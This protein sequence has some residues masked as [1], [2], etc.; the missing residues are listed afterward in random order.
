M[1]NS[2]RSQLWLPEYEVVDVG[3]HAQLTLSFSVIGGRV[4]RAGLMS[5]GMGI[6]I[7]WA[8]VLFALPRHEQH[9]LLVA[10]CNLTTQEDPEFETSLGY[11]L[12]PCLKEEGRERRRRRERKSEGG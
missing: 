7:R 5:H 9:G 10:S 3:H 1:W 6:N 2:K 4:S 12:R 11:L 8:F